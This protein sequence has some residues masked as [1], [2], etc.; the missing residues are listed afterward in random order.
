[1]SPSHEI[2]L[3]AFSRGITDHFLCFTCEEYVWDCDHLIEEQLSAP[4]VAAFEGS[5]LQSFA[6][7]GKLRVLETVLHAALMP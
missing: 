4:R 6:Y 1:M 5:Q 7:D 2:Q 3:S